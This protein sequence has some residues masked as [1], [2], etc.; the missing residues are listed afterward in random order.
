MKV[1][2]HWETEDGFRDDMVIEAETIEELQKIAKH[3]V[4]KRHAVDYWSSEV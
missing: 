1:R 4:E 2:I 3:E